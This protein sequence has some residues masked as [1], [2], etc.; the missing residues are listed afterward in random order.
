MIRGRR[1]APLLQMGKRHHLFNY[2]YYVYMYQAK[3]L[4]T[5]TIVFAVVASH[6]GV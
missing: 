1:Y 4:I 5:G 6:T 2:V 3:N